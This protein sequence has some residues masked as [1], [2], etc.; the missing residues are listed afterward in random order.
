[1][2][3]ERLLRRHHL[4]AALF[5]AGRRHRQQAQAGKGEQRHRRLENFH[6]WENRPIK[7]P[8]PFQESPPKSIRHFF[9][10]PVSPAQPAPVPVRLPDYARAVS[11]AAFGRI[12]RTARNFVAALALSAAATR[13]AA[14]ASWEASLSNTA[15]RP[16]SFIAA[17]P[18]A[19]AAGGAFSRP[20]G[21]L[22]RGPP[23]PTS[24][25]GR[26]NAPE[27]PGQFIGNAQNFTGCGNSH[28]SAGNLSSSTTQMPD[29]SK[30]VCVSAF[31]SPLPPIE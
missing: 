10:Q 2:R 9:R 15:G 14:S 11:P 17:H 8:G 7:P 18:A 3:G 12:N 21:S 5:R 30:I 27:H 29:P 6:G 31:V 19:P 26:Q 1:M 25:T 16:D 28:T 22:L 4:H 13:C 23:H 20:A 24:I